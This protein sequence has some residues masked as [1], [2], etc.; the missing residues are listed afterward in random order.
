VE[1]ANAIDVAGADASTGDD[2]QTVLRQDSQGQ[3]L[4]GQNTYVVT[5]AKGEVP[6]VKGFWS[7]TLY[8]AEHFFHPNEL[9][10]YALDWQGEAERP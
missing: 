4:T 1:R 3:Q 10:R 2:E 5:F 8:D 9:N 6:P 7:L